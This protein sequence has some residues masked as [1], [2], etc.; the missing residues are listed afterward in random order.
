MVRNA[1]AH[2]KK[3]FVLKLD[4]LHFFDSVLYS[5]V[6]EAAFPL[7]IYSEP[8]RVLLAMLCYYQNALPQGAP[9]SPAIANLVLREFDG[10]VGDWCR[11]RGISYTRYCDD[12]TFSGQRPLDEVEEFVKQELN[13]R[14]FF[15]RKDKTRM[16]QSGCRQLV[17]GL[18]VNDGVRLPS[19][20]RRALRQTIY[21]CRKFGV[22]SHLA[23]MKSDKTPESYL[24][25]LLGQSA[26]WLQAEPDCRE[27]RE[28]HCWLTAELRRRISA[29]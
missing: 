2:A 12:L 10:E 23:H 3:R 17:T 29:G 15:L 16:V 20:R 9:T 8:V 1:A 13:K 14:G 4:I 7:E 24:Q 28:V 11:A 26:F 5:A 19:D 6:K 21:F 25:S 27:A 18:V 22:E